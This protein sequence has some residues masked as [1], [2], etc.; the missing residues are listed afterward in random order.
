[1]CKNILI[2]YF[3]I[4][5][6][7]IVIVDYYYCYYYYYYSHRTIKFTIHMAKISI[8]SADVATS[9]EYIQTATELMGL[10]K[11]TVIPSTSK[12]VKSVG[13]SMPDTATSS[14]KSVNPKPKSATKS[15]PK[16]DFKPIAKPTRTP[17]TRKSTRSRLKT[18][19]AATPSNNSTKT[20]SLKTCEAATPS[21]HS[22]RAQSVSVLQPGGVINQL[23]DGI[24]SLSLGSLGI[25]SDHHHQFLVVTLSLTVSQYHLLNKD[26]SS[27][28]SVLDNN[29]IKL[30][31][32]LKEEMGNELILPHEID[33][34]R[35]RVRA[36]LDSSSFDEAKALAQNRI[37][38]S[39]SLSRWMH[40]PTIRLPLAGL[41]YNIS[42]AMIEL[43]PADSI[44][45]NNFRTGSQAA[46]KTPVVTQRK[47]RVR[48]ITDSDDEEEE[49]GEEEKVLGF[50]IPQSWRP[51]LSYL[52]LA[53][54]LIMP[55]TLSC[56]LV[57]DVYQ[58]L[59]HVFSGLHVELSAHFFLLSSSV[60][61][62][63]EA[64]YWFGRRIRYNEILNPPHT[65]G[66]L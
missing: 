40:L 31:S 56:S 17:A 65:S 16:I 36:L 53:Y 38:H 15:K 62:E 24:E 7:I 58:S 39:S 63:Q 8:T 54:Q 19:E 9:S 11:Q 6:I 25:T 13:E 28:L 64:V 37:L 66:N 59:G 41:Y 20:Q 3:T 43:L 51:V 30:L 23:C 55:V 21:H 52:L 29:V 1:M 27:C 50:A 42:N 33:S 45:S 26:T 5:L 14:T 57:R 34:L 12:D 48:R 47:R 10:E 32:S 61:L 49:K 2:K 46:E 44:Y 22:T 4:V 18:C 35:L 60:S